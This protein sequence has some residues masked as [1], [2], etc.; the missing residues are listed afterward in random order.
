M[1]AGVRRVTLNAALLHPAGVAWDKL[2]VLDKRLKHDK[3]STL[4]ELHMLIAP[5]H[6]TDDIITPTID[7]DRP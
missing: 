4:T 3:H 7:F 1:L 5:T 2:D 6:V